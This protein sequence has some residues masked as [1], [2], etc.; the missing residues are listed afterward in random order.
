[1]KKVSLVVA[2]AISAILVGCQDNNN[3][4]PVGNEM[5]KAPSKA[6]ATSPD[7]T[8]QLSGQ[9]TL[10]PTETVDQSFSV[11]GQASYTL[12]ALDNQNFALSLVADASLISFS[13]KGM[14][15][16]IYGE[17]IDEVSISPKEAASFEKKFAVTG[18]DKDVDLHVH[19]S[20]TA[21]SVVAD[22]MWLEESLPQGFAKATK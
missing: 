3:I 22:Y 8:I 4:N 12:V 18:F 2:V 21:E 16:K 6:V 20:V 14:S 13:E 15:G 7:G 9:V 11:E 1:M 5:S 10:G 19:F 17:S